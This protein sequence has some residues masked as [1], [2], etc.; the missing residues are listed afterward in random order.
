[1]HEDFS[2]AE[3]HEGPSNRSFGVT[4]AAFFLIV[5]LLPVLR[6]RPPRWWAAAP[7]AIL[8][9]AALLFPSALSLPN[10]LWM[11]LA[12]LISKIT[13][14]IITALMFYLLFTPIAVICRWTGKDLL[15]LKFDE[16][17]DTYWIARQPAGPPPES[18]RNQF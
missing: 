3:T 6:S 17:L 7:A 4:L 12:L 11:K 2:R 9:A 8:L 13:N 15:R 14:P 18:M 5:T 10:R 16:K 1:M